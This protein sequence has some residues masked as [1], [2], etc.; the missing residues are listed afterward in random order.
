MYKNVN[1]N[2]YEKIYKNNQSII[3]IYFDETLVN[4]NYI[5]SLKIGNTLF[6]NQLELGATPCQYIEL[7][8]HKKA[9]IEIPKQIRIEYGIFMDEDF[10]IIPIGIYNIDEFDEEDEN[11]INIKA[12]DNMIKLNIDDGYYDASELIAE[13]GYATLKQ[14]AQDICNKK[15]LE[16]RF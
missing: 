3:N 14:I 12:L 8:I 7:Q 11:V 10:E 16:L 9:N 13:N 15:G 2:W 5:T 6:D 4:S 1:V